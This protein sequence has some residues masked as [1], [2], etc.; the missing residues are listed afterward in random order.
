MQNP[1]GMGFGPDGFLYV[2]EGDCNVVRKI[3]PNGTLLPVVGT[4]E[5][6]CSGFNGGLG[7][8]AKLANPGDITL[9]ARGNLYVDPGSC[10]GI[11]RVDTTGH[12]HVFLPPPPA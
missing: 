8:S 2:S 10:G 5:A 11:L 12:V 9:D 1:H 3:T 6:G 4:G 7:V